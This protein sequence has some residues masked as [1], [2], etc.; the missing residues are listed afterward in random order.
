MIIIT[1]KDQKITIPKKQFIVLTT[2]KQELLPE[3]QNH[4]AEILANDSY[5][6]TK[7]I[8]FCLTDITTMKE[9]FEKNNSEV[10][11]QPKCKTCIFFKYCKSIPSKHFKIKPIKK[12][13]LF[14]DFEKYMEEKIIL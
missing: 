12:H 11:K 5:P 4:F 2:K 9:L 8:P 13:K 10:E 3:L 1:D 14:K 7:N 6:L